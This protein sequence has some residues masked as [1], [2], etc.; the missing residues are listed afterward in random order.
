MKAR[1]Q[2]LDVYRGIVVLLM[3]QGHVVREL[4]DPS[5]QDSS[6]FRVHE[7]FHGI[8]GPG[9]LFGAG[10]T[11]GLSAQARWS[12]YLVFSPALRKRLKKIFLL[13]G[14]AYAVHLPFLS[15][16]KTLTHTTAE[17]WSALWSFDVLQCIGFGL[18]ILQLAVFVI[19]RE[20]W[21]AASLAAF[22]VGVVWGAPLIWQ[23]GKDLPAFLGFALT[24]LSGSVYPL[25]PNAAFLFAGALVSYEFLR[26]VKSGREEQF[27]RRLAIAAIGLHLLGLVL[28]LLPFQVYDRSDYWTTSPNFFLIKLGGICLLVCGAWYLNQHASVQRHPLSLRWLIIVGV[29]SLFVYVVHL[30]V[31]YGSVLNPDISISRVF[32]HTLGWGGSAGVAALVAAVMLFMAWS[33]NLLKE[34]HT[35]LVKGLNWWMGTVLFVEFVIRPY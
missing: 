34:S 32:Y 35:I 22:M 6:S 20:R 1:Y 9:F 4:L 16:S 25:M 15:L 5:L 17:G 11:F 33:W 13:L 23:Q 28:D 10:I 12:E 18:L 7:L 29:E 31:L 21:F 27:I 8:T 14:I 30:I 26:F 2:F 19:R 24:G 3:I